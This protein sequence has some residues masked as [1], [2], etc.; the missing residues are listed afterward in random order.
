MARSHAVWSA[1]A[2]RYLV[3]PPLRSTSRL[4]VDG[5][6]LDLTLTLTGFD[7]DTAN[8]VRVLVNDTQIGFLTKTP[9]NGV[10]T[11]RINIDNSLMNSDTGNTL[12]IEQVNPGWTWGVTNL[13]LSKS[14]SGN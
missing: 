12:R 7:I 13:V 10:R 4:T 9:N 1:V 3:I 14:T 8:E 11:T 5:A 2:A 6:R